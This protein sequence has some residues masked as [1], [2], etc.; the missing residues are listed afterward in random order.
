MRT[1]WKELLEGYWISKKEIIKNITMA[2]NDI[3]LILP[4]DYRFLHYCRGFVMAGY[5]CEP[6]SLPPKNPFNLVSVVM[7]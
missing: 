7:R 3:K 6:L 4:S 5:Y 2:E 1:L